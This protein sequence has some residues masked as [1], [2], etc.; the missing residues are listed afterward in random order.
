M[1][2]ELRAPQPD[3]KPTVSMAQ[4][5]DRALIEDLGRLVRNIADNVGTVSQNVS[6]LMED[7]PVLHSRLAGV[8]GR[9][10]RI[11]TPTNPPPPPI[12]ST[13][14]R[15]LIEGHPSQLDLDTAAKLAGA[16][17]RT[18]ELEQAIHETRAIVADQSNFMGMGKKGLTWLGSK[19]G[20]TAMAQ[21]G[22]AIVVLYEALKQAGV[23]K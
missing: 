13:G 2:D 16:I 14:V 7:R 20:R 5:T 19:E 1:V 8:E 12:N 17:A 23:L 4:V 21:A 9:L 15:A 10:A 22:A 3:A 11:E 18:T 6:T